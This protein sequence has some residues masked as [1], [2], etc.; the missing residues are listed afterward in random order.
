MLKG[1]ALLAAAFLIAIYVGESIGVALIAVCI[2]LT[3]L[4]PSWDPAIIIKERQL[5]NASR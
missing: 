2:T 1:L 4:P 5:N 3:L